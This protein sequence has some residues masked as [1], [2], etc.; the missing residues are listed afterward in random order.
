MGGSGQRVKKWAKSAFCEQ[1]CNF[2]GQRKSNDHFP[3]NIVEF[4]TLDFYVWQESVLTLK[5]PKSLEYP[6]SLH[7]QA[8]QFFALRI[9]QGT[10][11]GDQ[12]GLLIFLLRADL[13]K[14]CNSWRFTCVR[15][16]A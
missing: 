11:F 16:D 1:R 14:T 15:V 4:I 5:V 2:V 6:F 3:P 10:T 12:R 9:V 13:V 7:F 8:F